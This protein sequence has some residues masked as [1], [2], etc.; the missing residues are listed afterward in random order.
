MPSD[1]LLG[2]L[3][4]AAVTPF[5]ADG[6][7]DERGFEQHLAALVADGADGVVV[8]GTTGEG[9]T[10]TDAERIDLVAA[11]V[12]VVGDRATVL[13][14]TGS[15]DTA[16]AVVLSRAAAEAGADALLVVTP[17][18]VRPSPA[19]LLAHTWAVADA[20][21]LPVMLYDVPRRTG[22]VLDDATLARAARHPAVVAVKDAT[23]DLARATRVATSTGLDYYAGDDALVLPT[24]AT[25]GTGFVGVAANVA[26]RTYRRLVD[27]V[28]HGD[29]GL[30]AA[31][32]AALSPL[33]RALTTRVPPAAATKAVL[34]ALGRLESPR[35]RLPLV[36]PEPDEAA[37]MAAD[38]AE[39]PASVDPALARLPLDPTELAGGA[40]AAVAPADRSQDLGDGASGSGSKR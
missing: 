37:A 26:T 28:A 9:P 25:G 34:H 40:L 16:R 22:T 19:G 11:A 7:L 4:V 10:L 14:A 38:L 39:V 36:G 5:H 33:V 18:Y 29:P 21:D 20:T 35:V 8:A 17:P 1:P 30:A 12:D 3:L 31:T 2:R 13:A 32:H 24:L 27:A 6:S 23:G 15:S